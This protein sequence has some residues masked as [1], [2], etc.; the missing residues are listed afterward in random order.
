MNPEPTEFARAK[1]NR[2]DA[3]KRLIISKRGSRPMRDQFEQKER[4][5][6]RLHYDKI[7]TQHLIIVAIFRSE[8][9]VV[10]LCGRHMMAVRVK[11]AQ[12]QPECFHT[13]KSISK[14]LRRYRV[15]TRAHKYARLDLTLSFD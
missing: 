6:D 9:V 15:G 10:V 14:L 13:I 3:T 8:G 2:E 4:W 7:D 1:Q 5:N 11:A 12:G